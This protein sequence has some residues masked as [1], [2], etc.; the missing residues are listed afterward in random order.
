MNIE[1]SEKQKVKILTDKTLFPVMREILMRDNEIDQTKEHFWAVG[2]ATNNILLYIE[3]VSLGSLRQT[4]VEP[5]EVFSWALQKKVDKLILVHNHPS[6]ELNPSP[7]DLDLTDRLIQVGIIVN[8]PVVDHLIISTEGYYSFNRKGDMA[9][10]HKSKKYVPAYV[11]VEELKKEAQ[12]I[13]EE[14][15]KKEGLIEGKI[16]MAKMLKNNGVDISLI[17]ESSGL[18]KEEI[19]KL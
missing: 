7:E 5:M 6:G 3:L 8:L 4:I 10:L 1:L 17:A 16:E 15:G 13:G 2:L 14:K 12:R 9:R 11:Q 19:E 18:S